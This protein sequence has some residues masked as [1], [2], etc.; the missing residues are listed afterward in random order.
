[1][2]A[3]SF[4]ASFGDCKT[5]VPP[6]SIFKY[7]DVVTATFWSACPRNDLM[8]EGTY[9]LVEIL[10]ST[11]VWEP[12]YDDDDWCLKFMWSRP[13]RLS[14]RSYATIE[15]KIPDEAVSGVYRITHFGASKSLFGSVKHFTGSSTAFTVA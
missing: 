15:W 9:A 14:T 13:S 2:D 6:D 8:T 4:G 3:T 12:A 10:K 5:D 11:D 1:M 7:G